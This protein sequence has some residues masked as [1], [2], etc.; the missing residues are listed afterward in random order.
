M[1]VAG[2]GV[3]FSW[4]FMVGPFADADQGVTFLLLV[5]LCWG[6]LVV[7]GKG[8]GGADMEDKPAATDEEGDGEEPSESDHL[9]T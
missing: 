6:G 4:K 8:K 3:W 7:A 5:A 9:Q 2:G 1:M